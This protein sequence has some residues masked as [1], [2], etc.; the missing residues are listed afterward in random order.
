MLLHTPSATLGTPAPPFALPD[1]S[2]ATVTLD[3]A[4]GTKGLVVA[5]LCNHCPY[6]KG[7]I[8]RIVLDAT[9]LAS[10][11]VGFVAIMSNDFARYPADRPERMTEFAAAHGFGFPYLLDADQSIARAYGAVCTP[12]FFGY[13]AAATLRYRGRLDS[14]GM[15]DPDGRVAELRDAML[16]IAAGG[17]AP[18]TQEASMGC[19]IKW[20]S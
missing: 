1:L 16:A 12:D 17:A 2:G 10:A 3:Q 20:K 8:E 11:G 4:R 19:S 18:E 9:A 13:D 14:A 6:V 7:I 15:G 5:F